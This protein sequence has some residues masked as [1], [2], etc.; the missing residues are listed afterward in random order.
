MKK[1]F[2]LLFVVTMTMSC[3][4]DNE[5]EQEPEEAIENVDPVTVP[6]EPSEPNEPTEPEQENLML[7]NWK[8]MYI[9]TPFSAQSTTDYTTQNITYEF[10]ED[11]IV[12]VSD[13]NLE[14]DAGEYNYTFTLEVRNDFDGNGD[15][16]TN[17]FLIAKIENSPF[18]YYERSDG[19]T[20]LSLSSF[21]GQDLFFEAI[22]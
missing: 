19:L 10:R 17:D 16:I 14:H 22:E 11:G 13:D 5:T 18:E 9:Y 12:V 4:T 3:S 20:V 15:P 21:D 7:G 1:L 2:L 8:L 6:T